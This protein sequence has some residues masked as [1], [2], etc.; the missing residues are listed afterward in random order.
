MNRYLVTGGAGFIG[1]HLVDSLVKD[2]NDVIVLDDFSSGKRENL[3]PQASFIQGDILDKDA[4]VRAIE[5]IDLC[6]HLAAKPIVQDTIRRWKYCCEVNMLATVNLFEVLTEN[7]EA[8][9]PVVYASSCAVYGATGNGGIG[10]RETDPVDPQSPYAVDKYSCELHARVGGITRGLKSFGARFFNV[11]GERQ[12]P[13]SPYSGVV[14]KFC[15][16]LKQNKPL[17]VFGDGEQTRDFIHVSDIVRLLKAVAS[18]ASESAPIANFGTGVSSTVNSL[19]ETMM[20]VSGKKVPVIREKGRPGEVRYSQANIEHLKTLIEVSP[21]G[22]FANH[23][24]ALF[25]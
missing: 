3:N 18:V 9:I 16:N 23:L 11:Y 13:R 8:N 20:K 5:G 10:L 4:L 15:E 22:S 1:S 6:F 19:A 25:R 14:S 2:G 7:P 12:D 17:T 24:G 21:F